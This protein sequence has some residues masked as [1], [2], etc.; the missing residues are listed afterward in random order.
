MFGS[1]GIYLYILKSGG[2]REDYIFFPHFLVERGWTSKQ[3]CA[4]GGVMYGKMGWEVA[5]SG[6]SSC[7]QWVNSSR[8][9]D[10]QNHVGGSEISFIIEIMEVK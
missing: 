3:G 5:S 8:P 10:L 4:E 1:H 2:A 6:D 7:K 9:Y